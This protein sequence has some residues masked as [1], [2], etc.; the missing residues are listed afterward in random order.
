MAENTPN[1]G[2]FDLDPHFLATPPSI[3][4]DEFNTE[5]AD[6]LAPLVGEFFTSSKAV[7][8]IT[9]DFAREFG[10]A[11]VTRRSKRLK[12]TEK[13]KIAVYL[14]YDRGRKFVD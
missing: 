5:S 9:N 6:I 14:D 13:V 12:D 4:S 2:E 11:L 10:Y 3:P 7:I 8:D 1:S